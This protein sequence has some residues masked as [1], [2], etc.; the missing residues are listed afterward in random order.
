MQKIHLFL[1]TIILG[2]LPSC[3]TEKA[4]ARKL[5]DIPLL[6]SL[7]EPLSWSRSRL[8]QGTRD[9][10]D[11]GTR[12]EKLY[13]DLLAIVG[14][15]RL[16]GSCRVGSVR[17]SAFLTLGPKG[18]GVIYQ[19]LQYNRIESGYLENFRVARNDKGNNTLFADWIVNDSGNGTFAM[20][21]FE[22]HGPNLVYVGISGSNFSYFDNLELHPD[23]YSKFHDLLENFK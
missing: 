14:T 2:L 23:E 6:T 21:T 20:E 15:D 13:N 11:R 22:E 8:D 19:V 10:I 7:E 17:G 16:E 12:A 18:I 9:D 5:T 3:S 4:D 1:F